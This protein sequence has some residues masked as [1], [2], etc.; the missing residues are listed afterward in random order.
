MEPL[1]VGIIGC[2][3]IAQIMHLPYL[4]EL[5][6]FDIGAL[7]DLSP[8]VVNAIGERSPLYDP[9]RVTS[10]WTTDAKTLSR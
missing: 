4:A 10:A 9:S 3:E 8:T 5:P 7:C 1:R 6:Q 2:G